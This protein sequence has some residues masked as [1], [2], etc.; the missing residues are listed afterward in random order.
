MP[1]S[2]SRSHGGGAHG[3]IVAAVAVSTTCVLPPFL[4]GALSV[5]VRRDLGFGEAS[6]GL[7]VAGSFLVAAFM[8]ALAGRMMERIG[9][10][11]GMRGAAVIAALAL[12]G[13]AASS[14]FGA[15]AAFLAV[16]GFANTGAQT[17]SNLMLARAVPAGRQATAFGIK[18]SAIPAAML[19]G[20]IA[21]PAVA[22][23]I[24]WRWAFVGAAALALA[25]AGLVPRSPRP[26]RSVDA[27]RAR[28]RVTP[29]LVV[30][31][32]AGGLGATAANTLGAFLVASTVNTGVSEGAAGLLYALGS[33]VGLASRVLVGVAADRAR[34][35]DTLP[36]VGVMLTGG[37][38]GFGLLATGNRTVL[39]PAVLLAYGLG[40]GWPGLFNWA[41]VARHP[42]APAAATGIT[43]TGV[44]FGAVTGPVVF[45]LLAEG[46]SYRAAWLVA[47]G[48][49]LAAAAAV[50]AAGRVSERAGRSAPP[51]PGAGALSG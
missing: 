19:L 7:A 35:S 17:G 13:M 48:C 2:P 49:S 20:G 24:G 22:L 26:D 40:W 10:A 16:A 39:I 25:S 11:T 46:V 32:L 31:G 8:S 28:L 43:Q 5:Q 27:D 3:A 9:P 51:P 15:L 42:E 38:V 45:G 36:M 41:V 1:G 29:T 30:L 18:Q 50:L 12:L 4:V 21:V 44:Y 37:A 34:R 23:T 14:S 6:L 33:A 47:L